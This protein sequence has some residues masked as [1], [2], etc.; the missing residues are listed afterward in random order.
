MS[1]EI[2][3]GLPWTQG[4]EPV[5]GDGWIQLGGPTGQKVYLDQL[6]KADQDLVIQYILSAQFPVLI[7]PQLVNQT[8]AAN[9]VGANA[10]SGA[11]AASVAVQVGKTQ[12][13]IITAMLDSWL[14]SIQRIAEEN[15]RADEKRVIDKMAVAHRVN[16]QVEAVQPNDN[17]PI[18][19]VGLIIVGTGIQATMIP[20]Q[21]IGNVQFNPVVN[22]Y[23]KVAMPVIADINVQL[24]IVGAIF[25]A[26]IQYFTIAQMASGS[27]E[28]KAA[29][30]DIAFAKGYA[31]NMLGLVASSSFNQYLTAIVAQSVPKDKAL[32]PQRSIELVAMLKIILLSSALAMVYKAEAG[33]M[34]GTEFAG[35]LSGNIKF[36]QGDVR[37]SLI[38]QIKTNLKLL[39]PKDQERFLITLLEYFDGDPSI[40]TLADPSKVFAGIYGD[41]PRGELVI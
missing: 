20:D 9:A 6:S 22:M 26:G 32:S 25:A 37:A 5:I 21:V 3:S 18:F 7:P 2:H 35:M 27:A 39:S 41:V 23:N 19:A 30:K 1:G 12:H 33:K 14:A 24:G 4:L 40:D 16:K 13:E 29:K 34:T 15:K 28:G 8:N 11:V 17:F 10:I 38:T 31:E 36:E